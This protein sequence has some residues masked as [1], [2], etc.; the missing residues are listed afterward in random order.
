MTPPIRI[1]YRRNLGDTIPQQFNLLYN[2]DVLFLYLRNQICYRFE[3][4]PVNNF[5]NINIA[6]YRRDIKYNFL[7]NFPAS[8]LELSIFLIS[9]SISDL[10]LFLNSAIGNSKSIFILFKFMITSAFL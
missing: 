2:E 9:N 7:F 5:F 10:L 1:K 8:E 4:I 6:A 3:K